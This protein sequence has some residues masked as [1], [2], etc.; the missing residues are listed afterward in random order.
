MLA[1][2]FAIAFFASTIGDI[3]GIGGGIIKPVMDAAGAADVV[4]INFLSGCTARTTSG[5]SS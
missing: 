2:V 3:C 1:I 5:T 4:T